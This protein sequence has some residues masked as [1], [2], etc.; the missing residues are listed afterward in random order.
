[1]I[2]IVIRNFQD[3]RKTEKQIT[4]PK[5]TIEEKYPF[6]IVITPVNFHFLF[7]EDKITE[8]MDRLVAD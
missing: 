8:K 1:M 3:F 7:F 4:I 5:G 6:L 2:C